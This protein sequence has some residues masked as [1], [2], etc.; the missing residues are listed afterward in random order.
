M[1]NIFIFCLDFISRTTVSVCTILCVNQFDYRWLHNKLPL[2]D[3]KDN[4]IQFKKGRQV[5]PTHMHV[6]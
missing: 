5:Q 4:S 6:K 1:S 2:G 3:N